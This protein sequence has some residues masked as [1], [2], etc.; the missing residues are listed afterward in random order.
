MPFEF[1]S[2]IRALV[3]V[4]GYSL[5]VI[6]TLAL[7][8]GTAAA[9]Y[10][11]VVGSLFPVVPYNKPEELVSIELY[12][13]AQSQANA[14]TLLRFA[15]YQNAS[16]SF[17]DLAGLTWDVQN[18]LLNDEPEG[19]NVSQ[20]TANYFS[21]LGVTPALGR[22]FL[23]DEGK[24]GSESVVILTDWFWRNRLGSDPAVLERKLMLN[25]RPYR[26]VGVLAEN[27]RVPLGSP[28][29]RVYLPY[30]VPSDVLSQA[31][32]LVWPVARLKPGFSSAQAQAEL[33]ALRP[34][35]GTRYEQFMKTQE[36][37]V[38]FIDEPPNLEQYRRNQRMLWT[39]VGA[40]GFLYAIACV[41]TGSLMLVRMLARRREIG[42]KLAL[43]GGRW[44]IARPLLL[45][46]LVL[47]LASIVAGIMVAKWLMP[48]LLTLAPGSDDFW[49]RTLK[50]SWETLGVLASLGLLT[51]VLIASWPAWRAAHLNVNDAVKE[52]GAA[53]GESM[54]LR[55]MRGSLVILETALAV[56]LLAGAGLMVRT[57]YQLQTVKPGFETDLRYNVNL[58]ISREMNMALATRIERYKQIA[59]RLQRVPGVVSASLA[60]GVVPN[61]YYPQKLKIV[62]RSDN[63]EVEAQGASGAAD[64]LE[65]LGVPLR[66]GRSLATLRPGDAPGVVINETM[67]RTYF[68]G[69]NP[70]GEQFQIDAKTRWEIIGVVG[71]MRSLRLEARPR[72]YFPYWQ[73]GGSASGVL[74]RLA[75]PPGPQFANEIRRAVYEVDP[76]F[77][78]MDIT[79][80]GDQLKQEVNLE[81]YLLAILGVLSGL[82][83]LLAVIGIFAMITYTVSQRRTEFGIRF[84]LG[85]TPAM[86]HRLVL[87]R[88]LA[89]ALTGVALGLSLAWG[90]TRFMESL[91]YQTK[92]G[93][94]L[95]YAIVGVVMLLVA[96]LACWL[97]AH[98]AGQV[99]VVKLLRAE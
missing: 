57:F 98:R 63:L 26:V 30:V 73:T 46:G 88:S 67:A 17:A 28:S 6:G 42:I 59:E 89:L 31:Y 70:V 64:F 49:F 45:E 82:A 62:G 99:D 23:P 80:L 50:F 29:G 9:F 71:D 60:T 25:G 43:G 69:R 85:A 20:V 10:T 11:S 4:P 91:L 35:T 16:G 22:N 66:A 5:V 94:P 39:G 44:D 86:I 7:G 65:V 96:A 18:L 21:V 93:D 55:L 97:P 34:E 58:R 14:V 51:G 76:K 13:R 54:R 83:L 36:A 68:A 53:M 3:R 52:D 32:T 84:A 38:R 78:V 19:L 47:A 77:A 74:M 56:A 24:A 12:N 40:I 90:L 33:R 2:V 87:R 75:V 27:Y 81:H 41:N 15:A 92:A 1:K 8:I 48:V 72:C 79:A 61:Y 95:T 37:T